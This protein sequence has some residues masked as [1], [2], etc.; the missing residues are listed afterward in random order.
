ML[1][2]ELFMSGVAGALL[3]LELKRSGRPP[4]CLLL[5]IEWVGLPAEARLV[6]EP[7]QVALLLFSAVRFGGWFGCE[8]EKEGEISGPRP[9]LLGDWDAYISESCDNSAGHV[10]AENILRMLSHCVC[11]VCKQEYRATRTCEGANGEFGELCRK[12]E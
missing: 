1:F 10:R 9:A 3:E 12:L 11:V 2:R 5:C 7:L 8:K 4:R 6:Y